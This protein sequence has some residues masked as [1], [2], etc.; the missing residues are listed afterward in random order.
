V[1]GYG[2]S[3][4]LFLH[5]ISLLAA[6]AGAALAGYAALHLRAAT[7]PADVARWG[8]MI[9]RVVR[10]FPPATL[11]LLS[12]G[13]YMTQA[14]WSWSTPWIVAGVVGLAMIV[15][16]G[17]GL[18]ASRGRQLEHEVRAHGLSERASRLLRDPLAW[19]AKAVTWTL[20]V[21]VMFVMSTKPPAWGCA[22]SL[23]GALI[24]GAIAAVPIWRGPAAD[25]RASASLAQDSSGGL[26]LNDAEP[27]AAGGRGTS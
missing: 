12:S 20:M 10:V 17:S 21:A 2:Y 16:L 6:G 1:D 24:I 5:L 22:I 13:A 19:T 15:L 4:A 25:L 3:I 8:M 18:E 11:G 7:S 9:G 26:A 23:L 27:A 14:A